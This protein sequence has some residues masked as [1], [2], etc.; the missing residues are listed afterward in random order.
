[1]SGRRIDRQRCAVQEHGHK[2]FLLSAERAAEL[3]A[4][5]L[6]RDR[7]IIAFPRV[8]ALL[9]RIGALLP[10]GLRCLT[11]GPFRFKVT[12]HD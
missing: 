5:G 8:L 2:P 9:T 1:M 12:D 7:S 4:D 3:I 11:S 6:A 10:E